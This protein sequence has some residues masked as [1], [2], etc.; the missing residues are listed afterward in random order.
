[1]IKNN[2][3]CELEEQVF[4][5]PDYDMLDGF[6]MED[7]TNAATSNIIA[8]IPISSAVFLSSF[9]NGFFLTITIRRNKLLDIAIP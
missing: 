3:F 2:V 6:V 8:A 7:S 5:K 9:F 4:A 1:M